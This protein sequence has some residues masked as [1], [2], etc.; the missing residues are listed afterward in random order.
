M[1]GHNIGDV[2]YQLGHSSISI[3]LDVYSHWM[4]GKFKSEIDEL[5]APLQNSLRN[6]F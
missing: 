3:T 1:R 4:P 5:D 6:S 2:S